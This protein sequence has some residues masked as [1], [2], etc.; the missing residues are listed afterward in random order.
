MKKINPLFLFIL[1]AVLSNTI[2]GLLTVFISLFFLIPLVVLD[3]LLAFKLIKDY[4]EMKEYNEAVK[5]HND[6]ILK[7][8][9]SYSNLSVN[10]YKELLEKGQVLT[11]DGKFIRRVDDRTSA[12]N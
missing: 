6:E 4:R 9:K 1:I 10:E 5:K 11:A 8:G 12:N 7:S 2:F 3:G